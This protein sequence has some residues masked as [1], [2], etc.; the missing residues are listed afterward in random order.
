MF[1]DAEFRDDYERF[2]RDN[3]RSYDRKFALRE[4]L[5]LT[6]GLPG[7][8]ANAVFTEAVVPI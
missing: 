4:L 3:Y 6:H 1:T 2:D 5:K 8:V 7:D